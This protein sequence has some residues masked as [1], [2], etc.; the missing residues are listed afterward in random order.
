MNV[1]GETLARTMDDLYQSGNSFLLAHEACLKDGSIS[2][3]DVIKL[4]AYGVPVVRIFGEAR[5]DMA[6]H[7]IGDDIP[8][9]SVFYEEFCAFMRKAVF[10]AV[11][12][13][14]ED[15]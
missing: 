7:G 4:S 6:F 15:S 8:C 1:I 9:K 13:R 14:K 5:I 11:E 10:D 2:M 3:G 12:N